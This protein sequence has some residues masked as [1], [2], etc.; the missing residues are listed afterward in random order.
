MRKRVVVGFDGSDSSRDALAFA[1]RWA[2]SGRDEVVV[3]T[4]HP[5]LATFGSR[6]EP[7][8]LAQERDEANRLLELARELLG[9]SVRATFERVEAGSAAHGLYDVAER[10]NTEIVIVG[11]RK[12]RGE[13][14]RTFPGSTG[15]RLL[16]GAA[17][18][19]VVVPT[20]YAERSRDFL[21][22]IAVGFVATPDGELA[23]HHAAQLARR[24]GGELKVITA[25]PEPHLL[26]HP[27]DRH[28]F[29][30]ADRQ[31]YERAMHTAID[32]LSH[33]LGVTAEVVEGSVVDALTDLRLSEV[34]LLV[35]GS[36]GYGPVRRVL[37]GGVSGHV[38]RH[39]RV[40]VL[41]VPRGH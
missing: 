32:T 37:L 34:D 28:R 41:V 31:D 39:S 12:H 26:P 18:A 3:V 16:Q 36:R 40:P 30:Q 23:L 33:G 25:V 15:E 27:G 24:I 38:I 17:A 6:A 5:G 1:A 10:E 21:H 14:R 2:G 35:I 8:W 20:G 29:G 11:A 13:L 19:V 22:R 7:Q 4:V 9:P